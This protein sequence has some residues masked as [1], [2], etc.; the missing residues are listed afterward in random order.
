[1]G[2]A[3][4]SKISHCFYGIF[5]RLKM[6]KRANY[7]TGTWQSHPNW[8]TIQPMCCNLR[9]FKLTLVC[10]FMMVINEPLR[11]DLVGHG[12]MI[13]S[14][15]MSPDGRHVLTGSFDYSA[16][17]WNFGDQQEVGRLN[18]HDGPITNVTYLR[19][20]ERALTASDDM[21]VILWD[22][23][24]QKQIFRLK[25]H[26]HKVMTVAVS[27]DGT[28][29][30]SGGWDS[31]VIIWDLIGGKSNRVIKT[32]GPVNSVVFLGRTGQIAVGGHD[33][34]IRLYDVSSGRFL[35]KMEGHLMGV[36]Q[37]SASADGSKLLSASIDGSIRL[38]DPAN[39]AEINKY[40]GHKNQVY[41]AR[42]VNGDRAAVS[43]GRDGTIIHWDL[44]TGNIL[45]RIKAHKS[46]IWAIAPS[47]D[48]RFV[49]SAGLDETARIW[50]LESGDRIGF[51]IGANDEPKPWLD[52]THPGAK[53]Y[54]KCARCHAYTADLI[55]RSGPHFENLFGRKVGSVKNYRY[56]A[57]LSN[58]DFTW[59]ED[60]IFELFDKGPDVIFPGTKMPV[61]KVTHA[62][63][64]RQLIEYLKQLTSSTNRSN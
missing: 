57:A 52:S 42:F 36:T 5:L 1:M 48:G 64:L 63:Q 4:I 46:I 38:W 59:T 31:K 22:I 24:R 12:G 19:D 53:L 6:V 3:N 62:S 49:V 32:K 11:A 18:G 56:S 28:I 9:V 55:Q 17:I 60:T 33:R 40:E 34:T 30:A 37:L 44:K 16:I 27:E 35:G 21:S 29:A 45:K 23:S 14:I 20:G 61:Q 47:S 7:S 54:K 15:D 39:L 41:S 8:I 26:T 10:L 58:K 13:R 43:T 51:E 25:G 2:N 50:H